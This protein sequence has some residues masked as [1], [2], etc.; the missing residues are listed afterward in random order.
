MT[1]AKPL[2]NIALTGRLRSGKDTVAAYLVEKYGYTR[3]AFG[4]ELKRHYHELF[5]ETDTKPREGYQWFGQTMRERDSDIWTRKC[6]ERIDWDEDATAIVISDIR[7]PNEFSAVKE[8]GYVVIRVNASEGIRVNRAVHSSD[9]FNYAD[10]KHDTESHVDTFEVD[11]DVFNVG[12]L[13]ELHAQI[14][15]VMEVLAD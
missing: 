6:F 7:Q 2:P 8:R 14:G 9:T 15:A 12:S 5:G 4:D 3:V 11:Y 1:L 13:D 10:L